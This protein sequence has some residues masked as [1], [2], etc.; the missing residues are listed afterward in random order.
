MFTPLFLF[1]ANI[2]CGSLNMYFIVNGP[3]PSSIFNI[4]VLPL[5]IYAAHLMLK[6]VIG[7]TRSK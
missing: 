1:A 2:L 6:Q 5:N 4:I 7:F 3:Y